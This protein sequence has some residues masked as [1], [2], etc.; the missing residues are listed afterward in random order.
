[1]LVKQGFLDIFTEGSQ[2]RRNK[3]QKVP[4]FSAV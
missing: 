4:V 3:V 2:R 1:M